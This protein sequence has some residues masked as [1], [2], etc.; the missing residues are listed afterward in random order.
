METKKYKV[1][2]PT[3]GLAIGEEVELTEA[4]ADSYNAGE[5][6]PRVQE[7]ATE[8]VE[9]KSEDNK[10]MNEEEKKE[11][12]GTADGSNEDSSATTGA[13]EEEKKDTSEVKEESDAGAGAGEGSTVAEGGGA[14]AE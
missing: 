5:T 1:L 3:N 11:E 6:R 4:Q 7:I 13:A 10:D 2:L 8:K 12:G 14:A 9:T